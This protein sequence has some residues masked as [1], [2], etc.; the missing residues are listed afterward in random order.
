[1]NSLLL[2]REHIEK[3]TVLICDTAL[4]NHQHVS[5]VAVPRLAA[6]DL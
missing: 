1:M 6:A 3:N 2:K 4:Q 5:G